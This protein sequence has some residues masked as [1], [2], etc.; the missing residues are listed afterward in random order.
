MA[1]HSEDIQIPK[2]HLFGDKFTRSAEAF[3]NPSVFDAAAGAIV[4]VL[5][6]IGLSGAAPRTMAALSFIGVGIAFVVEAAGTARRSQAM[7]ASESG[8]RSEITV[9]VLT[10]VFTGVAGFVLGLLTLIGV[11][12][13]VTLSFASVA[14]GVALLFGTGAAVQVDTVAANLDPSQTR[15]VIHEAVVGASGARVLLAVGSVVLGLLALAGVESVTLLLTA[16]LSL[17]VGVLLGAVSLGDRMRSTSSTASQSGGVS[18]SQFPAAEDPP[19]VPRSL[20]STFLGL[21]P[22]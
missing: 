15:R 16:G 19:R 2:T 22:Q 18:T 21:G 3:K 14:F 11:G 6:I 7:A 12:S 20:K 17:G 8:V 5:A 4:T 1:T 10:Q 13:L 9:S